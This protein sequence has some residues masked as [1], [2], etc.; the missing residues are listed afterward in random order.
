MAA[1]PSSAR[2]HVDVAGALVAVPV[3][4]SAAHAGAA[5]V[6]D[7]TRATAAATKRRQRLGK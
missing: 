7:D 5:I 3:G 1:T 2:L 6:T 4:T